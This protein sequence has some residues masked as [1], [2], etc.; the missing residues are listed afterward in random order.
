[1]KLSR[2]LP[3][4]VFFLYSLHAFAQAPGQSI[5]VQHYSY[6][7][8]L[9]D[10]ANIIQG[11]AAITFKALKNTR[12]IQLDLASKT[13]AGKG[14]KVTAVTRKGKKLKFSQSAQTLTVYGEV[15]AQNSY[16]YAITYAGVPADGLIISTS[17]YGQRTFFG[18]NWL[19]RAH[20]WLPCVDHVADKASVEFVVT[21]P[22]HYT[23]VANGVKVAE[24]LTGQTKVTHWREDAPISTKLMVIGAAGFAIDKSGEPGGIPVYSYVYK[25]DEKP[26]FKAYK[27]AA[28]ILPY[29]TKL[30]GPFAYK[31]L[32]NVQSKTMFGGMENAGAI[33]YYENSVTD[34]G[35]ES[36]VAHETAHQWFG[37][38]ATESG[39]AHVWL[40]E[41]FATYLAHYYH[42]HK[43]G[44]DSLKKRLQADKAT[45]FAFERQRKT[46]IVD[47]TTVSNYLA[48]LNPNSYQK[49]SWVLHMLRNKLGDTVFWNGVRTYYAKYMN[50]NAST[51]D[52]IA[53]MESTSNQNLQ[54]FFKQWLYTPLHPRLRITWKTDNT[55]HGPQLHIQQLQ[56]VPYELSLNITIGGT[57][58]SLNLKDKVH[59]INLAPPL[60]TGPLVADPNGQLLAEI[61]VLGEE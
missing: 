4:L 55:N 25:E 5:N 2:L 10:T 21:A 23:V 40:S 46:P 36:L 11:Q 39:P 47:T 59:D 18:D 33:F 16:V 24:T 31:K 35:I 50:G 54:Q 22:A 42:E 30:I 20:N 49:A 53:V 13:A 3:C 27:C 19:K 17:K 60:K 41:G 56:D 7:L 6:N 43:Y 58:Y 38:A 45:I 28:E 8:W 61:E 9:T 29:F 52:F 15:K 26:G 1:M 44:A 57:P 37:D 14:M 12:H 48:L 34:P 51:P 32:A